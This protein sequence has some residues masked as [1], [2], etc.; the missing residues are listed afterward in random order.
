MCGLACRITSRET[1]TVS[2]SFLNRARPQLQHRGPDASSGR[3][4]LVRGAIVELFHSRLAIIDVDSGANQPMTSSDGRWLLVFNGEI[5]NYREI[6]VDLEQKGISF[7]SNSDTEVLLEAWSVWGMESL[8]QLEGMFAFVVVNQQTGEYFACRDALG[9]KPIYYRSGDGEIA[10]SSEIWPLVTKRSRPDLQVISDYI[11]N[12]YYDHTART[13]VDD[14]SSIP[15]GHY[16]RGNVSDPCQWQLIDWWSPDFSQTEVNHTREEAIIAVRSK[17]RETVGLHLRSDVPL[18]IALSGGI[19]S[20]VLA[21]FAT[22]LLEGSTLVGVSYN[23]QARP[24]VSEISWARRVAEETGIELIE[25]DFNS[26]DLASEIREMVLR[27]GEPFSTTRIFAQYKVFEQFRHVGVKV[28]IEGQGADELFAGYSG[29]PHFRILSL[30]ERGQIG[31]AARYARKWRRFPNHSYR[32]L[33]SSLAG[34]LVTRLFRAIPWGTIRRVL[35]GESSANVLDRRKLRSLAIPNPRP[36]VHSLSKAFR[37]R[38]VIE[39]MLVALRESYIPQLVRQGDRNAMAWSIENRVPFLSKSLVEL[40]LSLPEDVFYDDEGFTK[41]L[42]RN[43]ADG[44]VPKD[45]LWRRDKVG[46]DTPQDL[47][48]DF[49]QFQ[50]PE[51][52]EK[53]ASLGIFSEK[54]V[55]GVLKE[56]ERNSSSTNYLPWRIINLAIWLEVFDE[57]RSE[58][59]C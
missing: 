39:A 9:I 45:V 15:G 7:R 31:R 10:F 27:Q 14:V 1:G 50:I 28:A 2:D 5:Y 34:L 24:D 3:S 26:Q 4:F 38:R 44:F 20:S 46:F 36:R 48:L 21:G 25:T 55:F 18:G 17:L 29:F 12:G 13:F 33:I 49:S 16:L 51:M 23:P 35:L 58:T 19:D 57:Q 41:P 40:V 6:R 59:D 22:E 56:A 32:R 37:G 8:S 11:A 54:V 53:L 47:V 30:I 52:V 42:L 43:A